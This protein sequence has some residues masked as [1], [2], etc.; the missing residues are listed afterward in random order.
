MTDRETESGWILYAILVCFIL[1]GILIGVARNQIREHITA[2]CTQE[3][4]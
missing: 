1:T 4:K 2:T 3:Q